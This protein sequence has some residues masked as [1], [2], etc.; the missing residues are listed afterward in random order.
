MKKNYIKKVS[1]LTMGILSLLIGIMGIVLPIVPTTPLFLLTFYAFTKSSDKMARWFKNSNLYK[2]YLQQYIDRK[3]LTRKQK[4]LMQITTGGIMLIP[5]IIFDDLYVRSILSA[6]FVIHVYVI[7]FGIKTYK[8][9]SNF[10]GEESRN[11][12]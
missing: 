1:Y 11:E 2:K 8:V 7:S 9:S 5:F 12:L 4:L 6:I 3:A 10:H